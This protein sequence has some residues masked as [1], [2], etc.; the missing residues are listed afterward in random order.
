MHN[1]A[2]TV[3]ML[4]PETRARISRGQKFLLH[5]VGAGR[6]FF[7][8]PTRHMHPLALLFPKHSLFTMMDYPMQL[9]HLAREELC[10]EAL[11]RTLASFPTNQSVQI[12]R[13]PPPSNCWFM[14]EPQH[15]ARLG[16][17]LGGTPPERSGWQA[18]DLCGAVT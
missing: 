15:C 4:S 10:E 11:M 18:D 9:H 7:L 14:Q 13:R 1:T 5:A 6:N 3:I 2:T 17:T 8:L 12:S 16:V